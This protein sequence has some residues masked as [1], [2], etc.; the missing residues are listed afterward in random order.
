M[1]A[2]DNRAGFSGDTE[3]T[4]E[5]PRVSTPPVPQSFDR[6]MGDRLDELDIFVEVQHSQSGKLRGCR[7]A[8]IRHGRGSMV[9]TL[10]EEEL[11]L[12]GAV[13]RWWESDIRSASMPAVGSRSSWRRFTTE[14]AEYPTKP[15]CTSHLLPS[16][17]ER[18]SPIPRDVLRD[19]GTDNSFL[20]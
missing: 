2:T 7:H 9:P 1:T 5:I 18:S 13:F 17:G 8:Q 14:R 19:N 16:R 15:A 12:H 3:A 20:R 10:G 11:D 6:L 4:V